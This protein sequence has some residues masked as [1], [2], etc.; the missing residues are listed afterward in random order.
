MATAVDRETLR[1]ILD[2][3]TEVPEGFSVH[4]KLEKGLEQRR[5]QLQEDAVDWST[6]EALAF[7]TLLRE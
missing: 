2:A 6:A 4:E 1:S 3:I 5:G 7:G